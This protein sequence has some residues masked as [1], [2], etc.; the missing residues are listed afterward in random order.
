MIWYLNKK[1]KKARYDNNKTIKMLENEDYWKKLSAEEV[2]LAN[3]SN[4]AISTYYM[5]LAEACSA[6]LDIVNRIIEESELQDEIDK[7]E[8]KYDR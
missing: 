2:A 6:N 4:D 1:E 8:G 5:H 7:Q 3:P